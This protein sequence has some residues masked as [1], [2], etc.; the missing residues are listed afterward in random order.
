MKES[1][2]FNIFGDVR[3]EKIEDIK[4]KIDTLGIKLSDI[5]EKFVKGSG[6]GG[7]KKNKTNNT[8]FLRYIPTNITVKCGSTRS[9]SL[10]RFIALRTLIEK[11]EKSKKL[12]EKLKGGFMILEGKTL[13]QEIHSQTKLMSE[14]FYKKYGR[15]PS[16]SI[17][18]YFENSPSSYYMNIKIKKSISLGIET[19]V[20]TPE[21]KS[22][23]KYFLSLIEKLSN[24]KN[25]DAI[26]VEKPLP[27]GFDDKDFWDL[28]N[29]LKDVDSL[30]SINMGNLFI[31]RKFSDIENEKFFVPQTANAAIKL[32]KYYNIDLSGK[33]A[34]VV[35]RSPIVGKPL[36]I[37]LSLLD[38][39]V[40]ICH[41]K[42]KNLDKYLKSADIIFTAIGK[43]KFFKED[44][45]GENQIIIDIG[46]NFDENGNMCGDVDFD[47]VKSKVKAITPVPG[48]VGPV[49]LALL[50]NAVVKAAFKNLG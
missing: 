30:S 22:D 41:S 35:G 38:A 11:I 36:S 44:M 7:Q 15:K 19:K 39:T 1:N 29:P 9:L 12:Q 42:T 46:T 3:R 14:N 10:N 2:F 5:E 25:V 21:N 37:M 32:V 23:K 16:L 40:T 47:S 18:N 33:N 6:K 49:T 26:M 13:S 4:K 28:L 31:T 8:V 50:L 24:D 17:I 45:I 34:V 20:Y 48:G 27:D 43:A